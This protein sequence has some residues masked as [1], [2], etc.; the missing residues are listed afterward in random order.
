MTLLN[1]LEIR[2]PKQNKIGLLNKVD[3]YIY[4]TSYINIKIL[5]K[6][7]YIEHI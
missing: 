2:V 1:L 3:I 4:I 5:T 6:R 7:I